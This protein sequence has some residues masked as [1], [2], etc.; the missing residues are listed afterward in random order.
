MCPGG[1]EKND[2]FN[3]RNA[4]EKKII[5]AVLKKFGEAVRMKQTIVGSN[6]QIFG[7]TRVEFLCRKIAQREDILNQ[8]L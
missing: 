6:C 8:K 3:F 4:E 1:L 5:D 2:S 7:R